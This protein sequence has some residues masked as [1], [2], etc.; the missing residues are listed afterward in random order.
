[1]S[2]GTQAAELPALT[3]RLVAVTKEMAALAAV[4]AELTHEYDAGLYGG[5]RVCQICENHPV[6][7]TRIRIQSELAR[8]T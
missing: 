1:M 5:C 8:E 7:R 2:I 6:H 3:N 4:V